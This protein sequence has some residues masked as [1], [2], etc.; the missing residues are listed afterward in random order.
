MPDILTVDVVDV[1]DGDTL[2]VEGSAGET[3]TVRLWGIDAPETSQPFGA[4]AT[5]VARQEAG[6]ARRGGSCR[7]GIIRPA[8][9]PRPRRGHDPGPHPHP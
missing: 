2:T 1:T 5:A 8:H 9:W 4:E 3:V 7:P 6:Q